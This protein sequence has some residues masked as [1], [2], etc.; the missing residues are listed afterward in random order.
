MCYNVPKYPHVANFLS[1]R[2][3]L[4]YLSTANSCVCIYPFSP[5]CPKVWCTAITS[6]YCDCMCLY[7]SMFLCV[8]NG[9]RHT[10]IYTFFS[11]QL[12]LHIAVCVNVPSIA[13]SCVCMYPFSPMWPMA[14]YTT[15][16]SETDC[17][18]CTYVSLC[19][20]VPPYGQWVESK[21]KLLIL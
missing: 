3:N 1:H 8:T 13:N 10:A 5:M 18:L 19:A 11:L 2:Y 15:T 20:H 4:Q 17:S 12:L 6:C 14:G 16:T 21:L 9:L 7:V